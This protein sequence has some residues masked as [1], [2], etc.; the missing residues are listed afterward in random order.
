MIGEYADERLILNEEE[1]STLVSDSASAFYPWPC[2]DCQCTNLPVIS[3]R[4]GIGGYDKIH[5]RY[6][7]THQN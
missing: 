4:G 3:A 6:E 5:L 1:E 7:Q 2:L